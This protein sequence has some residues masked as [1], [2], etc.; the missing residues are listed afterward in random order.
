MVNVTKEVNFKLHLILIKVT[1]G[2][3]LPYYI[4]HISREWCV[5]RESFWSL[6]D[7]GQIPTLSLIS[8]VTL[9]K[10]FNFFEPQFIHV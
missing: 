4:P 3:Q 9:H 6:T 8:H 2:Y 1:C 10:L 5:M 7:L